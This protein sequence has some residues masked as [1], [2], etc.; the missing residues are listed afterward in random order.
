MFIP[1]DASLAVLAVGAIFA[2]GILCAICRIAWAQKK[3][4][5]TLTQAIVALERVQKPQPQ[6]ISSAARDIERDG[7]ALQKIAI[8]IDAAVADLKESLSHSVAAA[9]EKHS[10]VIDSLRDHIDFQEEQ[11][12]K[13]L[14]VISE[15]LRALP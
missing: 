11:L 13:V 4:G 9:A 15:S 7:D 10:L 3:D 14:M 5:Q 1:I 2:V 6:L 12:E 8:Q